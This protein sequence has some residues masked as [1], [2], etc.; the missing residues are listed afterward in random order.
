MKKSKK[1]CL[2]IGAGDATGAEIG[3]AFAR[4]GLVSCLVRR[5]RVTLKKLEA[6]AEVIK[7]EAF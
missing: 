7:Q 2:V 3:K 4:E 1:A 6:L 5:D